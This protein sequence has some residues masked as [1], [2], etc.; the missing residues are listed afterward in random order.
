MYAKGLKIW[1]DGPNT[2]GLN[3]DSCQNVLIENCEFSTGDDCASENTERG[4]RIKSMRGR[5][6]YVDIRLSGIYCK[7]AGAG[8]D[9]CSLPESPMKNLI[10]E[11]IEIAEG[12]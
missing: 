1:T 7:K 6:G 9:L 4:I 11:K 5:G 2:D 8:I 3:P 12:Y 10:L